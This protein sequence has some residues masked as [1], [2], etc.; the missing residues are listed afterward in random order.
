MVTGDNI[1][2]A[3][4]IAIN[5]GIISASQNQANEQFVV[6]EGTRASNSS[7]PRVTSVSS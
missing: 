6:M 2:T 4:A 7:W 3:R 5:C 1:T